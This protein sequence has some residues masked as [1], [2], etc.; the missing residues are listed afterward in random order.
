MIVVLQH[1]LFMKQKR[2]NEQDLLSKK[3]PAEVPTKNQTLHF[4]QMD[5]ES[6]KK[7]KAEEK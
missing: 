7:K 3:R 6:I 5:D 4:K 1:G 2:D